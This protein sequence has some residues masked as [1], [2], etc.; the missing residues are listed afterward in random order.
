VE[1][2]GVCETTIG[3][4]VKRFAIG[5]L[6]AIAETCELRE[7]RNERRGALKLTLK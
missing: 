2:W 1:A 3:V 6:V 7:E 5:T 4:E